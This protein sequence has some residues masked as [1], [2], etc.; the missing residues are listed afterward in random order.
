LKGMCETYQKLYITL[1]TLINYVAL[2][3]DHPRNLYEVS[4]L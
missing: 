3:G 1:K 2:N 4:R